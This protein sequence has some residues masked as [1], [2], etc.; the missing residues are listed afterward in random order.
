MEGGHFHAALALA[1]DPGDSGCESSCS[2]DLM[3]SH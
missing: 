2:H 3:S 1:G